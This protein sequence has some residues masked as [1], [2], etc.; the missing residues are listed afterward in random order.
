MSKKSTKF[1]FKSKVTA[2]LLHLGAKPT[3]GTNSYQLV[4]ETQAG[5]LCCSV[6]DDMLATRFDD[7]AR[8]VHVVGGG[9]FSLISGKWNWLYTKPGQKELMEVANHLA[10]VCISDEDVKE[11]FGDIAGNGEN[12]RI[13]YMYRDASNYKAKRSLVFFG[14]LNSRDV[15][16][17]FAY[18]QIEDVD[19]FFIPGQIGLPDLQDSF[20]GVQSAWDPDEDHPYHVITDI[21]LVDHDEDEGLDIN[22]FLESFVSVAAGGG[23]NDAYKP[24]FYEVMKAR[25]EQRSLAESEG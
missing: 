17:L 7:P 14:R 15:K 20:E 8:A 3:T 18:S 5:L 11:V 25:Y 2:L 9:T 24:Y 22:A 1:D 13:S 21:E 12:T 4:L 6:Y 19:A 23:W 16:M 10:T